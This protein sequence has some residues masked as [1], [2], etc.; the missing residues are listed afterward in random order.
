MKKIFCC[1]M[2]IIIIV[3]SINT[4]TV[5]AS[6]LIYPEKREYIVVLDNKKASRNG[7]LDAYDGCVVDKDKNIYSCSLNSYEATVISRNDSVIHV[8]DNI[9]FSASEDFDGN[10]AVEQWNLEATGVDEIEKNDQINIAVLDSGVDYSSDFH[11]EENV[12][13]VKDG[14]ES[15]LFRDST[16]HGSA[17]ASVI[18]ASHNEYGINGINPYAKIFSVRVLDSNNQSPLSRIIEGIYWC[19]DNNIQIINMSFGT[20][21]DSD[22][23]HSAIIDAYNAGILIVAAAGNTNHMDVQYPAAY[24]EVVSVG[25][26]NAQGELSENTSIGAELD[27]LAP[28]ENVLALDFI[29]TVSTTS[30]TSIATAQV[31]GIASL[32]WAKDTTKS[33][34]FIKEL[35]CS[36]VNRPSNLSGTEAGIVNYS[37]ALDVYDEFSSSYNSTNLCS[38]DFSVNIDFDYTDSSEIVVDALWGNPWYEDG[39]YTLSEDATSYAGFSG[40]APILTRYACTHLDANNRVGGA[41]DD[42]GNRLIVGGPHGAGNYMINLRFLYL[43]SHCIYNNGVGDEYYALVNSYRNNNNYWN[44]SW[45]SEDKNFDKKRFN[46]IVNQVNAFLETKDIMEPTVKS[47]FNECSTAAQNRYLGL[48]IFGMAIH[49]TG[50]IYA[51]RTIVPKYT[52]TG[53]NPYNNSTNADGLDMFGVKY[54]DSIDDFVVNSTSQ[55]QIKTACFN[56]KVDDS[57]KYWQYFQLGVAYQV[58]EFRDINMFLLKFYQG[59]NNPFEDNADFCP[60]RYDASLLA[61]KRVA[62][63]FRNSGSFYTKLIYPKVYNGTETENEKYKYVKLNNFKKYT[64]VSGLALI[65]VDLDESDWAINSTTVLV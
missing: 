28:G 13:L 1:L 32:L 24:E 58:A 5:Q 8:E 12:D 44:V 56:D 46:A 43:A 45:H 15:A 18:A 4:L 29:D 62:E 11:V 61:C 59:D 23:L 65:G 49:L 19:I 7:F 48:M 25:S 22:I 40:Y 16:G 26:V 27:V 54:F 39:H 21:I 31:T 38:N 37:V 41:L 51:H 3:S 55:Q 6:E 34:V 52:V 60:E 57:I 33:N 10:M 2:V 35:L 36:A 47:K 20:N 14:N 30:G 63:R 9:V 53:T 50:D 42:N 17:M 64:E